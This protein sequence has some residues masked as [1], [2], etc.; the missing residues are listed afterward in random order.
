[1]LKA[2]KS[3]RTFVFF[4][5]PDQVEHKNFGIMFAKKLQRILTYAGTEA[6]GQM[7]VS[8]SFCKSIFIP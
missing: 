3:L 5:V 6:K 7:S 4:P 8:L 1:M 2:V